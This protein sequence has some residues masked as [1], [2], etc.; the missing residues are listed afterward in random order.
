MICHSRATRVTHLYSKNRS[1]PLFGTDPSVSQRFNKGNVAIIPQDIPSLRPLLPPTRAEIQDAM[2]ALFVG[3]DVVPTRQNIAK[4]SPVLVSRNRVATLLDFLLTKNPYYK[5]AVQFS[6]ENLDDLL[7]P[8]DAAA[9]EGVPRGVELCCLPQES[10][11]TSATEGYTVRGDNLDD[12][13]ASADMDDVDR[14]VDVIMEAVGYTAGDRT[15]LDYQNM[16]AAALAWC[17]DKKKFIKMQSG[18]KFMSE[19]DVGMLTYTFPHLDPWGIGGFNE[20]MRSSAQQALTFERQVRNLLLRDDTSFQQDPNFAYVCWNI[21]Q[22]KE[23]IREV[24][25]RTPAATQQNIAKEVK[26]VGPALTELMQKWEK[27]PHARPSSTA[28]K[29]ALKVLNKLKLVAKDLKGSSGYKQ[30]RRNEIR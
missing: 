25:F 23:V 17:L 28:E 9:G 4:L 29:K 13:T 3:T 18:S 22:K 21:L 27:N 10:G 5:E 7:H 14:E 19:R 26:E 6:Q 30:C 15:P 24:C 11:L 20:P 2:C 16:K 1:S 8:D 12:S